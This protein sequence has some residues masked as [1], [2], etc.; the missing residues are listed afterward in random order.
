MSNTGAAKLP[1]LPAYRTTDRALASWMQAVT[2][3]I[4]LRSGARGNE[5]ER[6]VVQR[7]LE[8]IQKTLTELRA[9]V[10]ALLAAR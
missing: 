5:A 2:E 8:E 4:E 1:G 10:Q 6:S 9:E 7:D 3:H